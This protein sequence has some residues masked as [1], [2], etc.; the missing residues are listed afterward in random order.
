MKQRSKEPRSEEARRG[1]LFWLALG[2]I[3]LVE[4]AAHFVQRSRVVDDEAWAALTHVD[5]DVDPPHWPWPVDGTGDP[6]RRWRSRAADM[7]L[8]TRQAPVRVAAH[9]RRMLP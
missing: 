5:L 1:N 2:A 8:I 4:V 6:P 3:A 7:A 9:A